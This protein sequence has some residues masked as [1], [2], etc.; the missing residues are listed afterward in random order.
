ML[1]NMIAERLGVLAALTGARKLTVDGLATLTVERQTEEEGYE[2]VVT[3]LDP[4]RGLRLGHHQRAALP[5][6]QGHH[7]RQEEA[8]ADVRPGRLSAS[9][10]PREVGFDGATSA[11]VEQHQAPPALLRRAPR[12]LMRARAASSWSEFLATE[13]FV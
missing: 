4:G 12:S 6:L 10:P 3:G 9:H 8:G 7:G 2:K 1:A 5:L 13:K 11:V